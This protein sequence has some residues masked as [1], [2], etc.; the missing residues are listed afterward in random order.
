MVRYLDTKRFFFVSSK[1]T[2]S[3]KLAARRP[4]SAE[5]GLSRDHTTK[6]KWNATVHFE[7]QLPGLF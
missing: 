7:L 5:S 3:V 6:G 1:Y 2:P 4:P